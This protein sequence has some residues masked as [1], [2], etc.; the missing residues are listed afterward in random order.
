MSEPMT[1]YVVKGAIVS[2]FALFASL[3]L[4]AGQSLAADDINL[5][6]YRDN[7]T[8]GTVETIRWD[9][10]GDENVTACTYEAGDWTVNTAGSI[11]VT[12]VT[13]LT[14]TGSDQYLDIT[15]TTTANVTGGATNPVISYANAGTAGSV[16]LTEGAMSAKASQA[17]T[18]AA[19]PVITS[20]S[21]ASGSSGASKFA[22]LVFNFSE[23]MDASFVEDTEFTITPDPGTFTET[24]S[25]TG[26]TT[27]TLAS[28][29]PML[30]GTTYTIALDESTIDADAGS[31]ISLVTYADYSF[32]VSSCSAASLDT[33]PAPINAI[34]LIAGVSP[35]VFPG[36]PIELEWTTMGSAQYVS[37]SYTE[38]G[39][40]KMIATNTKNDGE[41]TWNV[42]STIGADSITITASLTDLASTL[43][44]DSATFTVVTDEDMPDEEEV[45]GE[46][47]VSGIEPGDVVKSRNSSAVY[48][49][50]NDF[51]RRVFLD[52]KTYFTWHSTFDHVVTLN[53]EDLAKFPLE[54]SML[55]K[56][57]V[58]LVK[59]Q[60][61]PY[62]YALTEGQDGIT[63]VLRHILTENI[64]KAMYGN[65][66]ADYVIDIE[67]T[68][69]NR[70]GQG[71][72]IEAS[73][74]IMVDR[75]MMKKR[76]SL[77]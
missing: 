52:A 61:V 70:F 20:T 59:I 67:P 56:A 57:G 53:D 38:N 23:P 35:E 74:D 45:V 39:V 47:P 36:Q 5:A 25:G 4:F 55:P 22:S 32:I 37:L 3:F 33:Q 30:C 76:T 69:F 43:A 17:A 24:W 63:P 48:Y 19:A 2:S 10:G 54:G 60:S 49:I 73:S 27:V 11:G 6:T 50:T 77:K 15:V 64:A 75:T 29:S 26:D 42:P 21:P 14:C 65:D 16:T 1:N 44:T 9:M 41:F 13:A 58:V 40:T 18:D 62:V 68:F 34:D 71:E 31:V 46:S 72:D 28:S 51:G 12:A 8:N 66:W 7:N